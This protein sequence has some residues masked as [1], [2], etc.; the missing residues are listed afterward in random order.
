MFICPSGPL[1]SHGA[2]TSAPHTGN[3]TGMGTCH[4]ISGKGGD[5]GS[6]RTQICQVQASSVDA[7]TSSLEGSRCGMLN[8]LDLGAF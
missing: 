7:G 8:Y 5:V 3:G 1:T 6:A 4:H 2:T